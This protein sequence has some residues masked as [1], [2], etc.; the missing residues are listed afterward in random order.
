MG[1]N[2]LNLKIASDCYVAAFFAQKSGKA[3]GPAEL[4]QPVMPL[5][6][7][8]WAAARGQTIYGPLVQ[9]TDRL[10]REVGAFH[11]PIEFPHIFARGGFDAVIGNP[12]W[13]RIKLQ[14]QEFF[15]SR[16]PEIATAPNKAARERLIKALEKAGPDTAEARLLADFQ[17]AK[18]ATE[19]GSEF[20]HNS[21]RYPLTG[22]GDVNT[23][24]LFAEDFSRLAR[25]E[26]RSGLIVP[27][28]IV[29][30]SSTSAFFS[31][32]NRKESP[33]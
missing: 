6:D 24:S 14:E 20:A 10:A 5:T 13:E 16:S 21:G 30:D 29:T 1:R 12:P 23:Y 2:W 11:W 15:S 22:T 27:T 4:A 26:G 32:P 28:G 33:S 31:K 8:V 7:H 3:P 25:L 17:F 19:A 18:R 9:I